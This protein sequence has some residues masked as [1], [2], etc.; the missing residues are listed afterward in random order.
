MRV[1]ARRREVAMTPSVLLG[2]TLVA[3][4]AVSAAVVLRQGAA[5]PGAQAPVR[6]TEV[7]RVLDRREAD[8]FEDEPGGR[9]V[10]ALEARL[11]REGARTWL[12]LRASPAGPRVTPPA[13]A[14]G[15]AGS[16]R[17]SAQEIATIIGAGRTEIVAQGPAGPTRGAVRLG[18]RCDVRE[19]RLHDDGRVTHEPPAGDPPARE[20]FFE[21]ALEGPGLHAVEVRVDGEVRIRLRCRVGVA[22]G[23]VVLLEGLGA[24]DG[25]R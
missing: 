16:N 25:E 3:A 5:P 11:E 19:R 6:A 9:A 7:A 24:H 15:I 13:G 10:A 14:L 22:S 20:A 1:G 8:F 4:S 18:E 17:L 2:V 23:Q 12:R 21:V